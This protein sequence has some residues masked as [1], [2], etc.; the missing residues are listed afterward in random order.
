MNDE[1]LLAMHARAA[2]ARL[3]AAASSL[4]AALA[5]ARLARRAIRA[6]PWA[7][8]AIAGTGGLM[9]GSWLGHRPVARAAT[10]PATARPRRDWM[11]VL[12]QASHVVGALAAAR[13]AHAQATAA[14]TADV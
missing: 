2:R 6:Q 12:T 1:P 5:P 4:G 11:R 3:S 10:A 8:V 7:A 13:A 14:E 9:I